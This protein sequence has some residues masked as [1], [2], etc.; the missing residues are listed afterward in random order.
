VKSLLGLEPKVSQHTGAEGELPCDANTGTTQLDS[1][2]YLERQLPFPDN[3]TSITVSHFNNSESP[4]TRRLSQSKL[5]QPSAKHPI[6]QKWNPEMSLTTAWFYLQKTLKHCSWSSTV[7][8]VPFTGP[9]SP[10][11]LVRQWKL[12]EDLPYLQKAITAKYSTDV[13]DTCES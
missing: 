11:T 6:P 9:A 3:T 4:T 1:D 7:R 2:L 8:V 13:S 10:A 5:S 12:C